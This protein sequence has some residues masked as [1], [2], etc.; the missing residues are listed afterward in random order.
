MA[1]ANVVLSE[2]IHSDVDADKPVSPV[3]HQE[4]RKATD[5]IL[6]GKE[7][8]EPRLKRQR[9]NRELSAKYGAN[10]LA[11]VLWTADAMT[12]GTGL[13][14]D[15]T[16]CIV[17][18]RDGRVIELDHDGKFVRQF[19]LEGE[20]GG[21]LVDGASL[22]AWCHARNSYD[23]WKGALYDLTD[24]VPRKL[25]N[26]H[27]F[28]EK[29]LHAAMVDGCLAL[30]DDK[31]NVAFL[32]CCGQLLW[33]KEQTEG[34]GRFFAADKSGVYFAHHKVLR[35]YNLDSGDIVWQHS[36]ASDRFS[37]IKSGAMDEDHVYIEVCGRV[38]QLD[39]ETG[40]LKAEF[41]PVR[42]RAE[43]VCVGNGLLVTGSCPTVL[44]DLETAQ[45]AWRL[46]FSGRLSDATMKLHKSGKLFVFWDKVYC[47]NVTSHGIQRALGGTSTRTFER[48]VPDL[49]KRNQDGAA[50][51]Q[52]TTS[53][54]GAVMVTCTEEDG[55]VVVRSTSA[56][57]N[58]EWPVSFP[59]D[60]A[61]AGR[62]YAVQ[63]LTASERGSFYS[64]FG[65]IKS[66]NVDD[67]ETAPDTAEN[68]D[69]EHIQGSTWRTGEQ[70]NSYY[71][72]RRRGRT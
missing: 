36:V 56:G 47:I 41:A 31:G 10:F 48:E 26:L 27:E 45:E 69:E 8:G 53:V 2:N 40:Q 12:E 67:I 15:E 49:P 28:G 61:R 22:Y 35:R 32:G 5:E 51:P 43:G 20:V 6:P 7:N 44:F 64:V 54:D 46:D 71:K 30:G 72:G 19:R 57:Y 3:K 9:I 1:T 58:T 52:Q 29:V 50:T 38:R 24:E 21:V 68:L 18:T 62:R 70:G 23:T 37:S 11:P 33:T 25:F 14:V 4:K 34:N 65:T 59:V 39:K 16:R 55:K 42:H 66:L 63:R 60:L 13:F 17:G